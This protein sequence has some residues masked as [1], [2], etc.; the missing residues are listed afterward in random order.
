MN[1]TFSKRARTITMAM[2][3]I[4]FVMAAVGAFRDGT[5][6]HDHSWAALFINGFFFFGIALGT[7]FFYALQFA[8]ETSWSVM[9]RRVYE[10][11]FSFLPIGAAVVLLCL[12]PSGV[13]G[14]GLLGTLPATRLLHLD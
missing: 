4:G 1:F 13:I 10:G 9:V 2:M 8:T 11:M 6:H 12:A 7:L 5:A 14:N 3:V